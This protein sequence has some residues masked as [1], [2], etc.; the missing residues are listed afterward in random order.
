[1]PPRP[2]PC[3]LDDLERIHRNGPPRWRSARGDR[4]YEFDSFHGHVEIYDKRG[5][6]LAV[7]DARTGEVIGHAVKGRTISV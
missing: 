3:F 7:A 4:L 2:T 6:H 5:N 1:M